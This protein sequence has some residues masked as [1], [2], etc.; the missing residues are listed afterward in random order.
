MK[1][2]RNPKSKVRYKLLNLL[3]KKIIKLRR[4]RITP[5]KLFIKII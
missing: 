1:E 3:R 5:K 2:M 4:Q